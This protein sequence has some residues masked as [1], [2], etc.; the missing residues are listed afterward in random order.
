[1]R[2]F[3]R[4]P[5]AV[6]LILLI[7]GEQC[8]GQEV[9]VQITN[10]DEIVA[11][12]PDTSLV[13]D[14]LR[15]IDH[16]L[17][18]VA[19]HRDARSITPQVL[20]NQL[21]RLAA[22]DSVSNSNF[23][24]RNGVATF[25]LSPVEDF[26]AFLESI[27]YGEVVSSDASE[28]IVRVKVDVEEL[29]VDKL[30]ARAEKKG[31]DE[32]DHLDELLSGNSRSPRASMNFGGGPN[33]PG[34]SEN[35]DVTERLGADFAEGDYVEI[36]LQGKPHVGT[37]LA[38]EEGTF[39]KAQAHVRLTD[40]KPLQ[41]QLKR[42]LQRR[43]EKAEEF[44]FWAPADR[45]RKLPGAPAVAA[46]ERT[47]QDA[48]GKFK[49]A[50]TYQ[51]RDGDAVVLK[52]SNGK[53]TKVPLAKLSD[54]DRA[55]V[56]QLQETTENPFAEKQT[57]GQSLRADWSGVKRIG[58]S[59]SSKWRWKPPAVPQPK[60]AAT[61]ADR[62]DLDTP[63]GE[64]PFGAKL[65]ELSIAPDGG[66]AVA[67]METGHIN[68]RT[69][70]QRLDLKTG[71][72]DALID[73]PLESRVL[74][75]SPSERLVA[76]TTE[77]VGD[78]ST[79][80]FIKKLVDGTLEPVTDFDADVPDSFHHGIDA[81]RILDSSRVLVCSKS[82]HWTIWDFT[83]GKAVYT[84][85]LRTAF[86]PCIAIDPSGRY[87]F[88]GGMNAIVVIDLDAGKQ[89]ASLAHRF[90]RLGEIS[91]DNRL[92]RLAI[93]SGDNLYTVD[94]DTGNVTNALFGFPYD[95]DV[96]FLGKF[97]LVENRYIVAP[98]YPIFLWQYV[99]ADG[100]SYDNHATLRGRKLWY[101]SRHGERS[102]A[103]WS[104]SSIPVPHEA[105]RDKFAELGDLD[106]L[107]ILK[108]ND[109][110]TIVADTD[111]D[112][113]TETRLVEAITKTFRAAGYKIVAAGEA[114]DGAKEVMVTCKKASEPVT[115]Q[116][117]DPNAK[118][119]KTD[120]RPEKDQPAHRNLPAWALL[121]SGPRGASFG[122]MWKEHTITPYQSSISIRLGDKE[123]WSDGHKVREGQRYW[124]IGKETPQDVI[125]RI[126]QPNTERLLE[127]SLPA[128][129][130]KP[131][132]VGGTY[133]ASLLSADGIVS[134]Y[135]GENQER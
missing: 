84:F 26:G 19:F 4:L 133:G 49:V 70:L 98:E 17:S 38:V 82:D 90:M 130:C 79:R 15:D 122:W 27:D 113:A 76:L 56:D 48:T 69:H 92:K 31:D 25:R 30:M 88:A 73:C 71:A 89:V 55:Y 80:L 118:P 41:K 103:S 95:S 20:A 123:I 54:A 114:D 34:M 115:V 32:A 86:S 46:E 124:P 62:I 75:A 104:I 109:P 11:S 60:A 10:A 93:S 66:S 52:L 53:E 83:T 134:D 45:L 24:V 23:A 64:G 22:P 81:A 3:C 78:N 35:P 28:R 126:T 72:A 16:D 5:A 102:G 106:D 129:M 97:L 1:M 101:A 33:L 37:I 39:G 94:L 21:I 127:L 91:I 116:I 100:A 128:Q 67:V 131:G 50:A 112:A 2:A 87:L 63:A 59:N 7:G 74:D 14:V 13:Q 12:L 18:S 132:P 58:L 51:K 99:M 121:N 135:L 108:V 107:I 110:V 125:T 29:Q 120:D 96:D 8:L 77:D 68:T 65:L 9:T 57:A 111:L 36:L 6:S 44:A 40:T 61:S 119:P 47:W 105:V 43:L 117:G 85:E 42:S